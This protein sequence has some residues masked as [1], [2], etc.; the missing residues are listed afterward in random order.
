MVTREPA[1]G[2]E[3]STECFHK[4]MGIEGQG[5]ER[6]KWGLVDSGHG[7]STR[8]G[9]Q[10]EKRTLTDGDCRRKKDPNRWGLQTEKRT[11]TDERL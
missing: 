11:L 1:L 9:L 4:G 10:T 3:A 8:R 5:L 2:G 6:E 7:A